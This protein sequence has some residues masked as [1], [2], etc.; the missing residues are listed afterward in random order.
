MAP[1]DSYRNLAAEFAAK[2]R[3]EKSVELR[4]QYQRLAKSY[5]RLAE[6]A[7]R[8]ANNDLAFE[9]PPL[10]REDRGHSGEAP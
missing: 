8:N 2:G 6:Q 1:A 7:D 4:L 9:F 10:R 3:V 5:L